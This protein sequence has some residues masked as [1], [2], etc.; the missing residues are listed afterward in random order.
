M[1]Q[2]KIAQLVELLKRHGMRSS[3][4]S[5]AAEARQMVLAMAQP[6]QTV[7]IG[8]SQ[9]I[10]ALEINQALAEKGCQVLDH[11]RAPSRE[12]AIAM[13]HQQ[14]HCDL[15]LCSTN[16]LTEKGQLVNVDGV[17]NRVGAMA[18]GPKKVA[19]VVGINKIV[20]DLDAAFERV[21]TVA[22]PKNAQ[23]LKRKTPC[24][25]VGR[26]MDCSSPERMC[27]V[28]TIIERRPALTD[29]E[30]IIVGEELGY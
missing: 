2:T 21:R 23:R 11:N 6:G 14:L 22:A 8:G 15:F 25:E 27:S 9:T 26:C 16:A 12:E 4:V 5:T 18:F 20:P 28:Y 30:L 10:A 17:G 1:D 3:F 29:L 24:A 13:R 19:V 7:G